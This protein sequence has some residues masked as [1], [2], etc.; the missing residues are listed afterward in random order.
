M[1]VT[2][3]TAAVSLEISLMLLVILGRWFLPKGNISRSTLSQLLLVYM[4][5]ASDIVD[6]LSLLNET[7]IQESMTMVYFTL[8]IFSWSLFQFS[9]NL[10]VTRGRSFVGIADDM[11]DE[12]D[13]DDTKEKSEFSGTSKLSKISIKKGLLS[14]QP[15][16]FLRF[17]LLDSEIWSI[18]VTL[19]FQDGP[20]L[21]LRLAAVFRF[22]VRTFV[23]MFFTCKNA[24]ILFLQ[25][26][27]L[28]AICSENK[29]EEGLD[30]ENSLSSIKINDATGVDYTALLRN[31]SSNRLSLANGLHLLHN[32]N[33]HIHKNNNE[34][35]VVCCPC[36][37]HQKNSILLKSIASKNKV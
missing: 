36:H 8:A 16:K 9:L 19:I 23:T 34:E 5:L 33:N 4:S 35:I 27:R 13:S 37:C 29:E 14:M 18:L 20:F 3:E 21:G 7:Q 6:L 24:I 25:I 10:V 30:V 22:N 17:D 28:S 11:I 1:S 26:Y 12:L 32:S 31:T 2:H 15:F